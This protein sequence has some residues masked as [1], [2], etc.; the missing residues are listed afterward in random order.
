MVFV[1]GA[2]LGPDGAGLPARAEAGATRGAEATLGATANP[3]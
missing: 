2:A 1:Y 3:L